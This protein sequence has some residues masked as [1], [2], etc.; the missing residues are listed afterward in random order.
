MKGMGKLLEEVRLI[1]LIYIAV[2]RGSK[3]QLIQATILV[4][5]IHITKLQ[6]MCDNI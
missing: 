4:Y 1:H 3:I 6:D 5:E 2:Q